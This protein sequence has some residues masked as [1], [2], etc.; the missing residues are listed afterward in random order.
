MKGTLVIFAIV[1]VSITLVESLPARKCSKEARR[2]AQEEFLLCQARAQTKFKEKKLDVCQL[3]KENIEHCV[4]LLAS[5]SSE[6]K[7]R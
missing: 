4:E 5:C 1:F 7:I 6:E 2:K 3:F